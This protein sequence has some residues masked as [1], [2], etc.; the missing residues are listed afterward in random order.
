MEQ[1]SSVLVDMPAQMYVSGTPCPPMF[2]EEA[3]ESIRA[4]EMHEV[5]L[6]ISLR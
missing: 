1:S 2:T 4:T 5:I 6:N 3:E